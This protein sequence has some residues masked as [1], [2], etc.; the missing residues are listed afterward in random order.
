MNRFWVRGLLAVSSILAM[1]A[2]QQLKSESPTSITPPAVTPPVNVTTGV[3]K[4][5]STNT[6][7]ASCT[8]EDGACYYWVGGDQ[9]GLNATGATV[10]FTQAKPVVGPADYHSLTELAVES[11]ND[12]Q[13][14]E[15][16]WI[17]ADGINHDTDP[18]LF[19]SYWVNGTF[20]CYNLG[21][22]F[23]ETKG[24]KI[25]P[26]AKLKVG[27]IGTFKINFS[28]DRWNL[29]YDGASVGYFP[30]S[31]WTVTFK[32]ANLIQVFGEVAASQTLPPESQM[33]DGIL[34]SAT[35][36]AVIKSFELDGT[37]S[38][39]DLNSYV[40]AVRTVYDDGGVGTTGLNYGGPG[41]SDS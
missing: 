13:I 3:V 17:V 4:S 21:C 23:V 30:E 33:G 34:G 37:T 5:S 38:V 10:S 22:G 14:V 25:H 9:Q 35:G 12:Q 24:A 8:S 32:R 2:L 28:D 7:P 11:S 18:S 15:L 36:S 29:Y 27:A 41:A 1:T 6:V 19:V 39:A 16:G 20:G 26:G 31:L 40:Y